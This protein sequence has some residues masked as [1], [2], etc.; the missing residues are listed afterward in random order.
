MPPIMTA[1]RVYCQSPGLSDAYRQQVTSRC[2][3]FVTWAGREL[4]VEEIAKNPHLLSEFLSHLEATGLT[5][6]TI[7][8]YRACIV[9]VVNSHTKIPIG[10]RAIRIRRRD[11]A[12]VCWSMEELNKLIQTAVRCN[13][14][15]CDSVRWCVW[16]PALIY[17]GYSSGQRLGDLLALPFTAVN[18]NG[19][20][21]IEQ[22]KTGHR[23]PLQFSAEAMHYGLMLPSPRGA[24]LPWP[25]SLETL[26]KRFKQLVKSADIRA[27]SFKW[28]RR[29]AGSHQEAHQPGSGHRLLGNS[30]AVFDAHYN[31]RSISQATPLQAPPL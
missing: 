27:G 17:A 2:L 10:N 25:Y 26:R 9:A 11:P 21:Y 1:S 20:W 31:D 13:G 6:P 7:R 28:L 4:T 18:P 22:N 30:R 3:R 29:A 24:W 14:S 15:R 5:N 19:V 12:P 16:W 8:G 23:L